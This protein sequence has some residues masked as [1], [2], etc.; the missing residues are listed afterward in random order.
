[1]PEK[2]Y[3]NGVFQKLLQYYLYLAVLII[4]YIFYMEL[5]YV[6]SGRLFKKNP[7]LC[8]HGE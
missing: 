2:K 6:D 8:F 1:M 3:I 4:F 5:F 7:V